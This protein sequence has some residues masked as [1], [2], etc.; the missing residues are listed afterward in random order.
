MILLAL[1]SISGW[2]LTMARQVNLS[3]SDRAPQRGMNHM[4]YIKR[5]EAGRVVAASRELMERL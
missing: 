4:I 5:D 3:T 1:V 2:I